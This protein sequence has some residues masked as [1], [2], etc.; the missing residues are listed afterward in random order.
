M[1]VK[2]WWQS[3]TII[4]SLVAIL[5]LIADRL[6]IAVPEDQ[7]NALIDALLAA[8]QVIGS[9][10]AIWGRIKANS[11]I[12][13]KLVMLL[14]LGLSLSACQ[15]FEPVTP[16]APKTPQQAVFLAES[17]YGI[18]LKIALKYESLP[19]C[20]ATQPVL[21]S[22]PGAVTKLRLAQLAAR[23]T[24]DAAEAT[25]RSPAFGQDV[26]TSSVTA[27]VNAVGAF[28]QIQQQLGVQP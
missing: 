24:L 21:C 19:R 17:E 28:N 22:D 5:C 12:V 16:P 15:I 18:A 26:L 13:P 25:V 8:G 4:G 2:L 11:T 7:R 20:G 6:H 23:A 14:A 3:R 9:L 27:A 10:I 1:D